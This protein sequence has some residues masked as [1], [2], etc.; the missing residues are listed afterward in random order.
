MDQDCHGKGRAEM[1]YLGP[2]VLWFGCHAKGKGK[3]KNL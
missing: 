1:R 3:K 2:L